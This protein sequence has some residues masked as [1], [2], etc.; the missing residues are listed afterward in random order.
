MIINIIGGGLAGCE[1]AWYLANKGYLV[2]LYEMRPLNSSPAHTTENLAELVCSNS[3]KSDSE[4]SAAGLLKAELRLYD[5]LLMKVAE[6]CRVPAGSALAVDRD[7]FGQIA[8]RLVSEHPQINVIRQEADFIGNEGYTV[9][10]TGPLASDKIISAL[11]EV[12]KNHHKEDY[13]GLAFVDAISPVIDALS[14][15]MNKA[16]FA[17]RYGKG[18]DDYLNLPMSVAEFDIFYE[19]LINAEV[20]DAHEFEDAA[21]FERCMPIEV[22]AARG[23]ETL[24]FGPM[25]PVGLINPRTG[26]LPFAVVQLRYEN[27]EGTA[28]N[29]VGFQTKM[30]TGAQ[31]DVLRLIPGLENAEFL[32]YGSIHRNTYIEAPRYLN[33]DNSLCAMPNV[34]VAG[35]ISGVEGYLESMASGIITAMQVDRKVKGMEPVFFPID[36][37]FGALQKHI[38]GEFGDSYSPGNFH[39]GMLPKVPVKAKKSVRKQIHYSRG[40]KSAQEFKINNFE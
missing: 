20:A 6:E 8:T 18:G 16:Y 40:V 33:K 36:T 1:A 4:D 24:L 39:F 37:S 15:D 9:L 28:F 30:K 25:R 19:A 7:A 34:F 11:G 10:A 26:E 17:G 2:N 29:I 32:R 38:A 21:V 5:S 12:I 14:I 22:I 35:Q 31:R 23:K 3:L 27:K 13:A